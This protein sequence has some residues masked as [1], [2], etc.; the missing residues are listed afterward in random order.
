MKYFAHLVYEVRQLHVTQK[1]A[2][3]ISMNFMPM[4]TIRQMIK[5]AK[6]KV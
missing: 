2:E 4:C 1:N 3:T 5:L 6:H